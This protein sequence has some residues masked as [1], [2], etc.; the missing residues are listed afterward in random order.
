MWSLNVSSIT[1]PPYAIFA[2][3]PNL[4]PLTGKTKVEIVGEGFKNNPNISVK[5]YSGKQAQ[6]VQVLS[7]FLS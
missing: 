5:F 6:E 4:G 2:I 1:G 3:K 7:I